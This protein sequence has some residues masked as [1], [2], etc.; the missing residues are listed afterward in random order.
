[1]KS[2]R[3]KPPPP[4]LLLLL[5]PRR[6]EEKSDDNECNVVVDEDV[7]AIT[8]QQPGLTGN[9]TPYELILPLVT[10]RVNCRWKMNDAAAAAAASAITW[11]VSSSVVI[12]QVKPPSVGH[13]VAR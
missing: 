5:L 8:R 7:G 11:L 10:T 1:M 13:S 9:T 4:L 12:S 2:Q 6:G 3:R